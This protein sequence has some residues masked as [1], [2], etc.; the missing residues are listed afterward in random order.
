MKTCG[1]CGRTRLIEDFAFRNQARGTRQSICAECF[2][3]YRRA[4]YSKNKAQ[5]ITRNNRNIRIRATVLNRWLFEYLLDHPCV[6]CGEVDPVVLEFDHLDPRTKRMDVSV[7]AQR[8]YPLRSLEA[9]VAK[10]V[11]R[12]ANDHRRRTGSQFG[13][14][15]SRLQAEAHSRN[16]RGK[17]Q[18]LAS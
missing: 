6:D 3:E 12:C 18:L 5:Y 17:S 1:Q 11:V 14:P 8:G 9:E 4:H 7:M 10:C 16:L 13:W 2:G 15:R